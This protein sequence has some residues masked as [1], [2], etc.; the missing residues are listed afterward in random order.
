MRLF[1]ALVISGLVLAACGDSGESGSTATS[2][3]NDAPTESVSTVVDTSGAADGGSVAGGL[4]LEESY[5]QGTWCDSQG[6]TWV[7]NDDGV[8]AGPLDP[9]PIENYFLEKPG[10]FLVSSSEDEFVIE[11]GGPQVTFTRGSC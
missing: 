6:L 8:K 11:Q 3:G 1:V 4:L 10:T 7:I 5:L 9:A 2:P